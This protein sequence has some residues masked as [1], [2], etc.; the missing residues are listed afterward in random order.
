MVDELFDREYQ[1]K[2]AELNASIF[3]A[4]DRLAHSIATAFRVLNRIEYSSPWTANTN[5]ARPR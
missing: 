4:A 1:A 2:R 3:S 5:R